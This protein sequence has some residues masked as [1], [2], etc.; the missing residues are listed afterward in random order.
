MV[1]ERTCM[2]KI[3]EVLKLRFDSKFSNDRISECCGLSKTS[4]KR[5]FRKFKDSGITWP[6]SEEITDEILEQNLFPK[7]S[8]KKP[9]VIN[10]NYEYIFQELKKPDV[11]L[12]LLWEEYKSEN[13]NGYGYSQFC[14]LYRAYTKTLNYSMRQEH[15]AG[16]KVFADFGIADAVK[17]IDPQTGER[18]HINLFVCVWGASN[19]TFSK[20]VIG[21]ESLENWLNSSMLAFEYFGCCPKAIIPDN[22]KSVVTKACFYEPKIN[23]SYAEFAEH[24]NVVVFPARAGHPKDKAKVEVGVKL[25]KRWILARLRNRIFHSLPELNEAI[26]EFLEIFNSKQMK[27]IKKSRKE[28]FEILDMP[29]A[30]PLPKSRYEFA[31]WKRVKVNIDYHIEFNGH[32]YSVPYTLV[33]QELEVKVTSTLV[34]IF[35]SNERICSHRR[36][37]DTHNKTVTIAEHMPKSHREHLEWTPSRILEWA[38]KYGKDVKELTSK[39]MLEHPFPEQGYRACLGI[40]R[41]EKKFTAERLNRACERALR[42]HSHS[43]T[44]VRNIL[45]KGLED[46]E[47]TKSENMPAIKHENVRGSE[48]YF[49]EEEPKLNAGFSLN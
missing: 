24:Y 22:P 44:A 16:E 17:V 19:Y 7:S 47:E 27:R 1:M 38:G 39:I 36:S 31:E 15:K 11:T 23:M 41:L 14:S 46:L 29:N 28:L 30:L 6:L 21:E 18:I 48:Y 10:L 35:K 2:R 9:A 20:A 45:Q 34:E 49:K 25:A 3:R 40:I 42:Y 32:Y 8:G 37:Y 12:A 33:K 26:S 43:Y 4:I 13:P 5:Y